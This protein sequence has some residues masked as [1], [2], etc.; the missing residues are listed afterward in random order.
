MS[1]DTESTIPT[2]FPSLWQAWGGDIT[3][4]FSPAHETH[5]IMSHPPLL[6]GCWAQSTNWGLDSAVPVR[7]NRILQGGAIQDSSQEEVSDT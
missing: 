2:V 5:K 3:F 4:L 1:A 7:P 6:V